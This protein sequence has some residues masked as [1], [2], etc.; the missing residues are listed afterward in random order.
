MNIITEADLPMTDQQWVSLEP[1]VEFLPAAAAGGDVRHR[2]AIRPNDWKT[3]MDQSQ[4]EFQRSRN[5]EEQVVTQDEEEQG[6]SNSI[7]GSQ[8]FV[9][10]V[11]D[12]DEYQ[13]AWRLLGFMIDCDAIG[14][15]DVGSGDNKNNNNGGQRSADGCGRFLIWAA[16]RACIPHYFVIGLCVAFLVLS[17]PHLLYDQCNLF[18][19]LK[20]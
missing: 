1:G 19:S 17:N 2:A 15:D 5:L 10:G 8:P 13:Q 11:S 6:E 14:D 3:M 18:L 12:Y 7:Y 9:E 20:T 16:V 4:R